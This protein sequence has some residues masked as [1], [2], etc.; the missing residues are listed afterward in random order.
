MKAYAT[1]IF[2]NEN[3]VWKDCVIQNAPPDFYA[4]CNQFNIMGNFMIAKE[5]TD[6]DILAKIE[7]HLIN[8]CV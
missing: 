2:D 8:S 6:K 1:I 4:I 3:I 7:E 5:I